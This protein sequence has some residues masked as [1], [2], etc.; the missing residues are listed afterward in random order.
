MTT[1]AALASATRALRAA[2]VPL[3]ELDALLLAAHALGLGKASLLAHPERALTAAEA[4]RLDALVTRRA[5]RVPLAYLLGEREFYGRDFRVTPDVLVPRPET[6]LLVEVAMEWLRERP[7][8]GW[9]ADVGTGSGTLAVTLAA[10]RPGLRVVATDRSP[11]ALAVAA[12]NAARHAVAARTHLVCTDLLGGVA[13]PL[14]LVVANLPYIPSDAIAGLMLEV[15]RHEPRLAL[16]GG[17]DGLAPIRRL[18]AQAPARLA[19]GGL[20]LLE[21]GGDQGPAV[22]AEAARLLPGADIAVLKDLAGHDRV[23]RARMSP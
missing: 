3:P 20:L 15:A 5:D 6:E 9:A 7:A 10:E 18:L 23:L 13:G 8:T 1:G 14:G 4:A 19:P 11:A 22:R 2:G 17:P 21:I 12:V 16:D